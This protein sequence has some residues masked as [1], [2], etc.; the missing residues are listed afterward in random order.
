M[1]K[2]KQILA[3]AIVNIIG[4]M[5]GASALAQ[6]QNATTLSLRCHTTLNPVLWDGDKIKPAVRNTLLKFAEAWA[7]YVNVAPDRVQN[8]IVVGG[9]A[10]Y[11]YTDKSDIDLHIVVD[12]SKLGDNQPMLEDYLFTKKTLWQLT[13]QITIFGYPIEP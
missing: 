11:N 13:H 5:S 12:K 3:F 2:T 6:T 10:H 8:V 1:K 7:A 4:L 9:N